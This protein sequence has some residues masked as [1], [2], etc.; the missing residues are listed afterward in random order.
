MEGGIRKS[1]RFIEQEQIEK[2]ATK[3]GKSFK[4]TIKFDASLY[5]SGESDSDNE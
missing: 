5:Q 2:S 1:A 3:I 4:E